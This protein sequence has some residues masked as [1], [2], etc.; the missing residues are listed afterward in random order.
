MGRTFRIN[1][2]IQTYSQYL[3][4][5]NITLLAALV[6]F[7]VYQYSTNRIYPSKQ[8]YGSE[9]FFS[10]CFTCI[11]HKR[12]RYRHIHKAIVIAYYNIVL[13]LL[14]ILLSLYPQR[15]ANTIQIETHPYTGYLAVPPCPLRLLHQI[16]NSVKRYSN[17]QGNNKQ[18]QAP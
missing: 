7:A 12:R 13:I 14:K 16:T 15:T 5:F 1:N 4:H 10:N 9:L 3:L 2:H 18:A 6:T 17:N 8:G 11:R